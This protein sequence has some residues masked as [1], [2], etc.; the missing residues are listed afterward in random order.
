MEAQEFRNVRAR[1]LPAIGEP[2]EGVDGYARG[3]W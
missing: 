3:G 1:Q 2:A